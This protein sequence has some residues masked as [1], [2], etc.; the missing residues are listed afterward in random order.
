MSD[1]RLPS[2]KT[3]SPERARVLTDEVKRDAESL[4]RK[5]VTLY[6]DGAH[7]ALG[8]GAW[9]DYFAAE[10]GQSETRGK[11]LLRAGRVI[12]EL[13]GTIVPPG[14]EA[15]ARELAPLLDE[16]E[17]LRQVWAEVVHLHPQPTALQVREVVEKH[18]PRHGIP[19]DEEILARQQR[20]NLITSL[21]R[22]IESLEG[23]PSMAVAEAKRLLAAGDAGPFTPSRFDRV[24]AY[25]T[26]WAQA[27]R[28][29]GVDG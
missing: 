6:E 13:Q 28:E 20:E 18:R 1:L 22:A 11:Q 23:P 5:L 29:A 26:A 25:A 7:T 2:R 14:N 10:F 27:L 8:Y 15:Q 3:L 16:P 12:G 17:T 4:W 19:L 21:D 9:D 24:A